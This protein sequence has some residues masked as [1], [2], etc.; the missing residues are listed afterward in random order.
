MRRVMG[1]WSSRGN[2]ARSSKTTKFG[3]VSDQRKLEQIIM[4]IALKV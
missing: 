2:S 1:S 3:E 4:D